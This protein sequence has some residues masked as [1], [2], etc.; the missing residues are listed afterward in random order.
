MQ[1][2]LIVPVLGDTVLHSKK[3]W[4]VE[5]GIVVRTTAGRLLPIIVLSVLLAS[6][7]VSPAGGQAER[8]R[9]GGVYVKNNIYGEPRS[10]D[11][12]FAL[13]SETIMIQMNIYDGLV[14]VDPD[15]G[16]VVPD[17]AERWVHSP[18]GKT[19]TFYLRRGVLFHDG[20][21]VTAADF[22]YQFERVAN[23]VNLSPHMARLTGVV[24][25]KEFQEKRATKIAGIKVLDPYTLQ[26]TLEKSSILLPYYLTGVW[27]SAVPRREVERLGA[28]FNDHPVGSGPFVFES[29]TRDREVVL[30]RNPR[31]WRIDRWGNRLP[32]VDKIVFPLVEDMNAVEAAIAV[33]RIDSSYI[34]DTAYMMY[35]NHPLFRKQLV[36]GVEYYTGH[37]GFNSEVK[38]APW[39][40]KRVRQAINLA[41]DRKAIV[42]VVRHGKGYPATGPIPLGMPGFDPT[43]KG[44]EYSPERAKQLLADAGYPNG[45]TARIMSPRS[46]E[47]GP[48]VVQAAMGYLN[49]VGIRLQYDALESVT[50]RAR[51]QSGQ[52]ELYAA[53]LGGE[54][55]PLIYLMRGFHSRF[56]GPAGNYSRYRSAQVDALLDRASEAR[57]S[58]TMLRLVRQA[59]RVITDDAPWWFFSYL[60]GVVVQQPYVRGLRAVP[61]DMDFQ[62]LEE[63]WLAWPPKRR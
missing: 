3:L 18:D 15:R 56:V 34:R 31:Y 9:Y 23:P 44:Y 50:Y 35:K 61:I 16:T 51:L 32:Y 47:M 1:L 5:R 54:G 24:G 36:E 59:E 55:H 27:A 52:F 8:P 25:V 2:S 37:I 63:V 62:P 39:Q 42:D 48:T 29:W 58:N 19:Y 40:D 30:R 7:A 49:A 28:G 17:I 38:D 33:G 11:P 12:L 6:V 41:I 57:D 53:T 14:K 22:K 20:S 13:G 60:K 21:Q 45:F 10:L 26:I 4:S 46:A 43:L